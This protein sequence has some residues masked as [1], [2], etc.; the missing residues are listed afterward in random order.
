MP[1]Y[2]KLQLKRCPSVVGWYL[3]IKTPEEL[4]EHHGTYF[5]QYWRSFWENPHTEAA[6]KKGEELACFRH[7]M[8]LLPKRFG[9]M[10]R[11][12][13]QYGAI[14][15]NKAGGWM[16]LPGGTHDE[17]DAIE[18]DSFPI[19]KAPDAKFAYIKIHKWP[20]GQHYYLIGTPVNLAF[21]QEKFDTLQE[22]M[23]EAKR[24]VPESRI[25]MDLNSGPYTYKQEGD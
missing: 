7:P 8:N 25:S 18:A 17:L 15:I 13:H 20:I 21:K 23:D 11:N 16:I 3:E 19:E 1:L 14:Y 5:S 10:W 24:H 9:V 4:D 6:V 12:L 2:K 22:A